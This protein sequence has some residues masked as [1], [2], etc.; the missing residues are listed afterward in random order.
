MYR[1]IAWF[2]TSEIVRF[3][4]DCQYVTAFFFF[5]ILTELK[6]VPKVK[7]P[8]THTCYYDLAYHT[9]NDVYEKI[10][11]FQSAE[12]RCILV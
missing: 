3:L 10:T 8:A 12:N 6:P 5:L 1:Y 7:A 2:S 9:T 4:S 11:R